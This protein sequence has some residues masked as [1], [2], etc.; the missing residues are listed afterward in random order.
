MVLYFGPSSMAAILGYT[1]ASAIVL[2]SQVVAFRRRIDRQRS[3][4]RPAALNADLHGDMVRYASP[5]VV[6]GALAWIQSSSDRWALQLFNTPTEVGLYAVVYQ[7]GAYPIAILFSTIGQ[8][9]APAIFAIAG[10]A[11]DRARV[12][13][14]IRW[15]ASIA[16]G[17]LLTGAAVA[18]V[19]VAAHGAIFALLVAPQYASVSYLLPLAVLSSIFLN[20][21]YVIGWIAL[22]LRRPKLLLASRVGSAALTLLLNGAGAFFLGLPGVLAAGVVS[23]AAYCG[24]T[25]LTCVRAARSSS[26][27]TIYVRG[28]ADAR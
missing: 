23:A 20:V 11:T 25:I 8:I 27:S 10:D 17:L 9:A 3:F 13:S 14:A 6:W 26:V 24:W 19:T 2:T 7:L 5:F 12:H 22:V 4:A 28:E 15:V 21:G 18:A 1:F 16:A